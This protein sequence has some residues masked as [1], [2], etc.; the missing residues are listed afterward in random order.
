MKNLRE[1]KVFGRWSTEL[2][3]TLVDVRQVLGGQPYQREGISESPFDR[4]ST[5]IESREIE[6]TLTCG[7]Y[8]WRAIPTS[9]QFA[10]ARHWNRSSKNED[11]TAE[12]IVQLEPLRVAEEQ[13]IEESGRNAGRPPEIGLP[14]KKNRKEYP[15]QSGGMRF[16]S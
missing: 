14:E 10:F 3:Q 7:T 16:C 13:R 2:L 5:R 6:D 9:R 4:I 12:L 15:R 8:L 11:R 1:L